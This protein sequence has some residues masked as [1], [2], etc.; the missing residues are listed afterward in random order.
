LAN[1][2][3]RLGD[4]QLLNIKLHNFKVT[5]QKNEDDEN[6]ELDE[7]QKIAMDEALKKAMQRKAQQ[8]GR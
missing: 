8:Y 1:I 6:F 5:G 7:N 4:K 2:I 3:K